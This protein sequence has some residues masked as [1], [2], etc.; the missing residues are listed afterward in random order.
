MDENNTGNIGVSLKTVEEIAKQR[1]LAKSAYALLGLVMPEK[2]VKSKVSKTGRKYTIGYH[3]L[4][5]NGR[6]M[7]IMDLMPCEMPLV[8]SESL[9]RTIR[10]YIAYKI[11]HTLKEVEMPE[12]GYTNFLFGNRITKKTKSVEIHDMTKK[13][14]YDFVAAFYK[15]CLSEITDKWGIFQDKKG[16]LW[17][18]AVNA[19]HFHIVE[20]AIPADQMPKEE[21]AELTGYE[22]AQVPETVEITD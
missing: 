14:A 11:G 18:L 21:P 17:F 9:C 15:D 4:V 3:E 1:E 6:K 2:A 20:I 12:T 22:S 13:D 5:D 8:D 16:K 7:G 19:G 10:A